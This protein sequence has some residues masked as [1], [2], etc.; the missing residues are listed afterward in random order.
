[1]KATAIKKDM[2]QAIDVIEDKDFLKA[3]YLI[4]NEKSREYQYELKDED[5]E[6]LD[7]LKK[8]NKAG[9]LKSVSLEQIRKNAFSKVRK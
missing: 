5:K 7:R 4:L 9:K 2:Y 3:V 8:Q 1:M 6:E